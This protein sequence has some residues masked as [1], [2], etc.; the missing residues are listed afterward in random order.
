M[1][2]KMS[3]FLL[4]ETK[5]DFQY[6]KII[7]NVPLTLSPYHFS[8]FNRYRIDLTNKIDRDESINCFYQQKHSIHFGPGIMLMSPIV[9]DIK[10]YKYTIIFL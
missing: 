7:H 3:K 4:R 2:Y 10:G 5:R 8:S 9:V 6:V 1:V